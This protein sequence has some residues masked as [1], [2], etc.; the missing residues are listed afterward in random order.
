M[1]EKYNLTYQNVLDAMK[2]V[3]REKLKP[4]N[5]YIK[6]RVQINA[7]MFYLKTLEKVEQT[8]PK[9][10]QKKKILERRLTENR[11]IQKNL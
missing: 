4:V 11:K 6:K 9:A 10:S 2:A 3:F 7:L 8:L 1:N 5:A